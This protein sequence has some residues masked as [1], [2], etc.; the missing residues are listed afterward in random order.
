MLYLFIFKKH[1][2]KI[3]LG[4]RSRMTSEEDYEY[5][6]ESSIKNGVITTIRLFGSLKLKKISE[7]LGKTESTVILHLKGL[8]E[9]GF[10]MR[11]S[12]KHQERGKF[13]LLTDKCIDLLNSISDK[14]V[15]DNFDEGIQKLKDM[16]KKEYSK[17]IAQGIKN[18]FSKEKSHRLPSIQAGA[19]INSNIAKLICNDIEDVIKV[20]NQENFDINKNQNLFLANLS[21]SMLTIQV[22]T[23]SHVGRIAELSHDYLKKLK[24]LEIEFSREMDQSDNNQ[25]IFLFLGPLSGSF[26]HQEIEVTPI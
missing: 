15:Y 14:T 13:Y 18:E 8:E 24:A 16:S 21:M 23:A 2:L 11:D 12:K 5:I 7:L 9:N 25:Y 19:V 3:I 22:S 1:I 20:V 26:S 4:V 10:I 6:T 17:Y